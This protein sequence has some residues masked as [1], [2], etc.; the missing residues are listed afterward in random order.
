MVSDP[1]TMGLGPFTTGFGAIRVGFG[2]VAIGLG[3]VTIR[4]GLAADG[5]GSGEDGIGA[6]PLLFGVKSRVGYPTHRS[7]RIKNRRGGG[8]PRFGVPP[9]T[10]H[11]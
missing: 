8:T 3:S 2:F 11:A 6:S 5:V 10:F 1:V 4:V 9:P 7:T